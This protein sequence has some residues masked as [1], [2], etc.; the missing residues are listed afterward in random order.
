MTEK[1][2]QLILGED[3]FIVSLRCNNKFDEEKYCDIKNILLTLVSEWQHQE[4]I[5]KKA[6]LAISELVECLVGG[7]RFLD[8]NEAIRVED[9]SIEIRDIIN[10]LYENL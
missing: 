6:M 5:P 8:E 4:A 3:G 7:N 10:N 1:L 9:A 2:F